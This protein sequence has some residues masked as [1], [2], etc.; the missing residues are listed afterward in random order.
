VTDGGSGRGFLN[1][2]GKR[3]ADLSPFPQKKK[4][5]KWKRAGGEMTQALYAHMNNKIKE[6]NKKKRKGLNDE[7]GT[8]AEEPKVPPLGPRH[9]APIGPAT[10]VM[11]AVGVASQQPR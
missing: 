1:S 6:I 9:G 7:S 11:G 3:F 2:P 4:K 10:S 5:E 8:Q